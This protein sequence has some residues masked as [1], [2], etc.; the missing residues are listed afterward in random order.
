ML[1]NSVIITLGIATLSITIQ[2]CD[3]QHNSLSSLTLKVY[4]E[5]ILKVTIKPIMLSVVM[6]NVFVSS[7]VASKLKG[8]LL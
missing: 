7:V 6:L 8:S 2:K 5:V 4:A 3:S 1:L